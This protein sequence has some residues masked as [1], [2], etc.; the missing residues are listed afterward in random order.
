MRDNTYL[1]APGVVHLGVAGDGCGC[2]CCRWLACLPPRYVRV[3]LWASPPPAHNEAEP[4]LLTL[5]FCCRLSESSN[6]AS[7]T[8]SYSSWRSASDIDS[9]K[10][11]T[12]LG[13]GARVDGR[14]HCHDHGLHYCC[15]GCNNWRDGLTFFYRPLHV[16]SS[17][18]ISRKRDTR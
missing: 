8:S 16:K 15:R 18:V 3:G 14:R 11:V 10:R 9:A 12:Y 17:R 1:V 7:S 2:C 5:I 6:V 13:H 4:K